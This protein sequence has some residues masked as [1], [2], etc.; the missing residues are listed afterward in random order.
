MSKRDGGASVTAYSTEGYVPEA[1]LNYLSLLGWSPGDNREVLDLAEIGA[2]FDLKAINRRN[3]IFDLDKCFWINGQHIL[4]MSLER[5]AEL[6]LPFVERAG[7]A[8]GSRDRLLPV[9]AI[10]KE[11]IKLLRDIPDWIHYFFT[12]EFAFD[13]A[14]V[15]KTLRKPGAASHLSALK[16]AYEIL[17]TWDVP[18]LEAQLKKTA[19]QIGCKTG[20]LIHPARV[21]ASGRSIGPSLYHMLE[22]LGKKR[23][24]ARFERAL[25]QVAV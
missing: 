13:P 19:T 21:A 22:V 10:V 12:E 2:L 1:V 23:V 14:S 11:K 17:E 5:F 25:Q 24:L 9:L 15:E 20:D 4:R 16:Q 18:A 3:A 7:I 6:A 8:Y